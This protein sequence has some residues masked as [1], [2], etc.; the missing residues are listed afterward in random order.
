VL[1]ALNRYVSLTLARNGLFATALCLR[2]DPK[3]GIIEWAS[4]GNPP[5]YLRRP[6]GRVKTLAPTAAMLGVLEPS[7]YDPAPDRLRFAVGDVVMAYT[8]GAC[9]A[10]GSDGEP[11]GT[12]GVLKLLETVASEDLPP[13]QYCQAMLTRIAAQRGGIPEDDTLIV[14]LSHVL[15]REEKHA[16]N[17]KD[18]PPPQPVMELTRSAS[19]DAVANV[20]I[21]NPLL[22]IPVPDETKD[23]TAAQSAG[24]VPL[25]GTPGEGPGDGPGPGAGDGPGPGRGA[26][27]GTT[28]D[29]EGVGVGEPGNVG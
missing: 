28:G 3:R 8:D 24:P 23:T 27:P 16:E 9:E 7:E 5:A 4:A 17:Q 25:P 19:A 15:I 12:G 26:A 21:Q 2:A 10:A 18:A 20:L 13:E 1:A 29:G 6:D 22:L 11:L 14:V